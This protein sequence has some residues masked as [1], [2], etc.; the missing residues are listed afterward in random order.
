MADL[1]GVHPEDIV[2]IGGDTAKIPSG[3][4]THSD[5]SMRLAAR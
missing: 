3:S 4:G 1:L 5:R 2:F